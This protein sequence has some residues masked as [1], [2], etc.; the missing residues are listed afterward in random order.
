MEVV[1]KRISKISLLKILFIGFTIS[2]SILTTCFGIAALFGFN[3]IE[4][5]G[6]Y[7]TGIEGV[8][9]GVLMG[10][11]FGAILSC[12]SWVAITLGLWVYSFFN[13]IKVS[14]RHVI[15]HQE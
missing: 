9:Y 7:K 3:T 6:E 1:A 12:M 10:P 13:P 4:W 5:F 2:M 15:E 8:F 11:I 14:F